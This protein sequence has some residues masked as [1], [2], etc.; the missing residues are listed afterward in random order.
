MCRAR[1]TQPGRLNPS[2]RQQPSRT[3]HLGG[4]TR[5]PCPPLATPEP[6]AN[7]L[8]DVL[9]F[10]S[11]ALFEARVREVDSTFAVNDE[12][13]AT[14]AAI[15][16]RLDGLRLAIELAAALVRILTPGLVLTRLDQRFELLT[17]GPRTAPQHQQTLRAALDS[18]FDLLR[19]SQFVLE[20][21][22]EASTRRRLRR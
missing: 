14:I 19:N 13:A 8:A 11:V 2:Q 21:S 10:D 12:N 7:S 16:R 4:E 17:G 6:S 9:G 5:Y 1:P 22:L 20:C 18:T 3:T 15:C